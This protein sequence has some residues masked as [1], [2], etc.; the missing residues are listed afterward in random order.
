MIKSVTLQTGSGS[1]ILLFRIRNPD[2]T[3][4]PENSQTKNLNF[5]LIKPL[6]LLN[7]IFNEILINI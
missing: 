1:Q 7:E 3:Y 4:I 2:P 5:F 6:K